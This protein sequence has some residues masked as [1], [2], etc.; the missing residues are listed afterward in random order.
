MRLARSEAGPLLAP[1]V[2]A[3]GDGLDESA[4]AFLVQQTLLGRDKEEAEA[5]EAAVLAELEE[6]VAVAEGRAGAGGWVP[7]LSSVVGHALSCGAVCRGVVL[8]QGRIG[9]KEG[10][11]EEEEEEATDEAASMIPLVVFLRPLVSGSHLFYSVLARGVQY[12]VFC[13]SWFDSGY[14]FLA[15]LH[16]GFVCF[17]LFLYVVTRIVGRFS[18]CSPCCWFYR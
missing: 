7:Y 15:S 5:V 4:V 9:Q 2:L 6:K 1:P 17:S 12:F 18:S 16:G 14:M 3:G 13:S 8:G 11:E 10:E